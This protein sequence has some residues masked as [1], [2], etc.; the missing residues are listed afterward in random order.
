MKAVLAALLL[1]PTI[2]SADVVVVTGAPGQTAVQPFTPATPAKP[3]KQGIDARQDVVATNRGIAAPTAITVPEGAVEATL[4][5]VVPFAGLAGLN[6]GIT[7]STEIW[8]EGAGAILADG[9]GDAGH[10]YGVGLK[11]VLLRTP[12]AAIAVTGS[13][14]KFS[15]NSGDSLQS[16]GA[17]GTLCVDDDCGLE[18]SGSIG[19][20]FGV[21]DKGENLIT[22]SASAG[23]ATTRVLL[24]AMAVSGGSIG[25]LGVRFG[26]RTTTMDL[27]LVTALDSHSEGVP[28]LPWVG[29]SARL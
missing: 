27:A 15:K 12:K 10:E 14:R 4:Q 9:G 5:A 2:A 3:K 8:L 16:I 7:K 25:F 18:V 1:L 21:Q 13:M 17:V 23:N 11:Q 26:N 6:A 19:R 29:F 22:L 28:A 24:E 20:V